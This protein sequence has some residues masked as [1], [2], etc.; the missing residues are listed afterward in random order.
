MD[1]KEKIVFVAFG[2][3]T[4]GAALGTK[5]P[6]VSNLT[7]SSILIFAG[8]IAFG[9]VAWKSAL[10]KNFDNSDISS[11]FTMFLA[12]IMIIA[13]ALNPFNISTWAWFNNFT[14]LAASVVGVLVIFIGL[15]KK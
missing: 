5:Y 2:L 14:L 10:D 1:W 13:G 6:I 7:N 15:F 11:W 3:A 8:I 4:I 12:T 9:S